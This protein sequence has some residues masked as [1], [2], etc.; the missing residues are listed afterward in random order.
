MSRDSSIHA[1]KLAALLRCLLRETERREKPP[2]RMN[3]VRGVAAH[4]LVDLLKAG[5][6][7]AVHR[8]H[9]REIAEILETIK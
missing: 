6:F 1:R 5:H 9:V 4:A 2:P 3:R 8:D 7:V